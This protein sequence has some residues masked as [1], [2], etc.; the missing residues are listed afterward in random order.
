M[1]IHSAARTAFVPPSALVALAR[2]ILLLRDHIRAD[3][4]DD[5]IADA[6]TGTRVVI[7]ADRANARFVDAQNAIITTA[8]LAARSGATVTLELPDAI[9]LLGAQAPLIGDRLGPALHAALGDLIPGVSCGS[10]HRGASAP[11]ATFDVAVLVGDTMWCGRAKR[12]L[13]L[14]ADAWGGALDS[15]GVGTRWGALASPFGPLAAGGLAAGEVFKAAVNR[16]RDAAM[17]AVAFDLLFAPTAKALVRLAPVGAPLPTGDLG[18]FDLIS[19][20]AIIQAALYALGRMVG[21]EGHGRLIEP[22]R[23]DLTNLNRYA[24]LR[25]SRLGAFKAEDIVAWAQE[26]GLGGLRLT[27]M[28]ARYDETL[29]SAIGPHLPAVLVGVDDIPTRWVVQAQR[30][31]WLGVGATSHYMSVSSYHSR[32]LGCAR[33]LHPHDDPGTGPI[34][35]VAFVSHWAGLWLAAMFA[36]SRS[37]IPMPIAQ[38][39]VFMTSLRAE[40]VAATWF[41]PVPHRAECPFTCAV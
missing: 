39:S 1:T 19:G 33:C 34:P 4:P 22:E 27:S 41:A 16:L 17:D 13:R 26:G 35:T 7:A 38:Q 23:G 32:H 31:E 3:V 9:P 11:G 2:T 12:I 21:V 30:P 24:L 8:L 14:Q 40:S 37:G 18:Q 28:V 10:E 20:G 29:A 5:V 36:R 15:T 25:R 6:L